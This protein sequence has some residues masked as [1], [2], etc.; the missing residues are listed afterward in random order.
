[1]PSARPAP[2]RPLSSGLVRALPAGRRETLSPALPAR[3][4]HH[5]Q[6]QP[7]HLPMLW[8]RVPPPLRFRLRQA[9]VLRQTP[10]A[11]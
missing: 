2:L 1:M 7:P 4:G 11:R 5:D 8:L 6:A 10:V 3:A 9:R